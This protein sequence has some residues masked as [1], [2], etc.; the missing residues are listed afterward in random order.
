MATNLYLVVYS[1]HSDKNDWY[2]YKR[3]VFAQNPNAASNYIIRNYKQ[4]VSIRTVEEVNYDEG[5]IL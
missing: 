1:V 5:T 4:N 3:Y 2:G